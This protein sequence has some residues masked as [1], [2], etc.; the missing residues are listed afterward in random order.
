MAL[1]YELSIVLGRQAKHKAALQTLARD[2]AD[3]ISA[4]TYCTQGGEVIPPRVAHVVAS[5]VPEIAAWATLGDVGRKRKGTVDAKTQ[6]S[7]VMDLLGVYLKDGS[8]EHLGLCADQL[9]CFQSLDLEAHCHSAQRAVLAPRL[10]QGQLNPKDPLVQLIPAQVLALIPPEW[11]VETVSTFF[12]RSLRRQLHEQHTWQILKSIAAG[13]NLAASEAHLDQVLSLPPMIDL[14]PEGSPD[15][16]Q[17][18]SPG[19]SI[20]D[21]G[22]IASQEKPWDKEADLIR[23]VIG[24]GEKE[25]VDV[26]GDEAQGEHGFFSHEGVAKELAD[27]Q[28]NGRT[29]TIDMTEDD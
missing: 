10:A 17:K 8:V 3:S 19:L 6:E 11:P 2:V 18:I 9:T 28:T 12:Q 16:R 5:H 22:S 23:T 25:V 15:T 29:G 1:K 21:E 27:I 24:R 7:L 20:P 13:Q 14:A 4:Q 26:S